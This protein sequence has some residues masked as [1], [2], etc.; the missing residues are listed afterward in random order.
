[1]LHKKDGKRLAKRHAY[2]NHTAL[3]CLASNKPMVNSWIESILDHPFYAPLACWFSHYFDQNFLII[4]SILR[5]FQIKLTSLASGMRTWLSRQHYCGKFTLFFRYSTA[6]T[7]HFV[8]GT[9]GP[10]VFRAAGF[11][12]NPAAHSPQKKRPLTKRPFNSI[13]LCCLSNQCENMGGVFTLLI[14]DSTTEKDS[15]NW[16]SI[17]CGQLV[18]ELNTDTISHDMSNMW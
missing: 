6:S 7:N 4:L 15:V 10:H 1:M 8:C 11:L 17:C 13:I 9:N 18:W 14:W 16:N 5:K 12:Q 3:R 2:W